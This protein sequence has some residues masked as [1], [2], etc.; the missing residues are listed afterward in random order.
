ATAHSWSP[1]SDN[2]DGRAIPAYRDGRF[3]FT[4]R[5]RVFCLNAR[6]PSTNKGILWQSGDRRSGLNSSPAVAREYLAIGNDQGS[7]DFYRLNLDPKHDS[8][9]AVWSFTIGTAGKVN[10]GIMSSPAISDGRVYFGG[11]DGILY[12][13]GKGAETAV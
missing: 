8:Q 12:G 1:G 11:E 7:L 4:T 2:P 5:T 3:F 6:P 13:L 10:G 9:K